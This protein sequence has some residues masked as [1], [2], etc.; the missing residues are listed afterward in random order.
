LKIHSS[1]ASHAPFVEKIGT[2]KRRISQQKDTSVMS[3][4]IDIS[5][6]SVASSHPV[7]VQEETTTEAPP[8]DDIE[9]PNPTIL[10]LG[11]IKGGAQKSRS[12]KFA[13]LEAVDES[14]ESVESKLVAARCLKH[15]RGLG[16]DRNLVSLRTFSSYGGTQ[17]IAKELVRLFS[18][19]S[20][21]HDKRSQKLSTCF[22]NFCQESSARFDEAIILYAKELC[23]GKNTS[24]RAI[25][26]SSSLSRCCIATITKC[27]VVLITLRAA[28]FC[29]FSPLWLSKLSQEA[30][31]WAAGDSSLRSELEEASRLLLIDG[32]VGRYCGDG[33]KE[34][35]H[36]DNPRHAIRLV[37]FMSRHLTQESILSDTLDLCE[38]FT[39]LSREEA[40]NRIIQN[41][42]LQGNEAACSSLLES[43]YSRNVLLA[44]TTFARVISFCV[45][46]IEE[47]PGHLDSPLQKEQVIFATSCAHQLSQTAL[48]HIHS[49]VRGHT[50]G[51]SSGHYDEAR[52]EGLMEDF[53]HLKVLQNSHGVFLSVA[54]L[55]DPKMLV[56]TATKFLVPLVDSY[57]EGTSTASST[58]ATKT[59]RVCS[60]LAGSSRIPDRQLWFAA[61][62]ASA[63]RLAWATSDVQ[64]L[65]FLSDLGVL[66][67]LDDGLS[68]RCCLAVALTLCKKALKQSN[69][70][71]ILTC[72]KY[73][74]MATSLLKD[75][76]IPRCPV[77]LL[78]A[79]VTV[80]ELCDIISQILVRA[81]EGI[82]E[83][84]DEF[85]KLLH[86]SAES[87]VWS[88]ALATKDIQKDG[89]DSLLMHRPSL[90]PSW[91]VGDGLLLPPSETLI[92]GLDFCKQSLARSSLADVTFEL[93]SFVEGRGAHALALRVLTYST[94]TQMCQ[95]GN[96]ISHFQAILDTH[97]QTLTALAERSLGGSGNGILSGVVDS[98]L[99]GSFLLCLPLK[100][101]FKVS[102]I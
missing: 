37:E 78:G 73:V 39:H 81:D 76:S 44:K 57:A 22:R 75:T 43:L 28:L 90:H 45:D 61:I 52:L 60:L 47:G 15:A 96:D 67:S 89:K 51:Y 65:E 32:I 34:L 88:S 93:F 6:T 50:G 33:A 71:D 27:Q 4:S 86:S 95:S 48:A 5:F 97:N 91:Y 68:A 100:R 101:A 72:M 80:E 10:E 46:M 58:I 84:V 54:D 31:E 16:L 18:S 74:I 85:R 102:S 2:K 56:E 64:C 21:T 66:D 3:S 40:C 7:Q 11:R 35:F 30:I 25:E 83:E 77:D 17:F 26:E 12:R 99:A 14:E 49:H 13:S 82:G 70:H 29:R 42:I 38:A 63:C 94:M 41:A 20:K 79:A 55:H 9:R 36:V 8:T 24:K 62:G 1:F 69:S 87:K 23:G 59:K 98:Q 53:M 92:Y 19:S